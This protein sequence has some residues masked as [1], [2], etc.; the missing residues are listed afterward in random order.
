MEEIMNREKQDEFFHLFAKLTDGIMIVNH[1]GILLYLNPKAKMIF[2]VHSN[3]WVGR[4]IQ[5]LIPNIRMDI[6]TELDKKVLIGVTGDNDPLHI[7]IQTQAYTI[8]DHLYQ[9]VLVKDLQEDKNGLKQLR[10]ISKELADIK[11]ALDE[12]TIVAITDARGIITLVN[13]KFCELSKYKEEELNG[14]NHRILNSGYHSKEF[15]QDM[16]KTISRGEIWKGEIQNKAKDGSLYWVDTTIV[17]FIGDNGKPYQYVSIRTDITKRVLMEQELQ[18]SMKINFNETMKNLQNGIFRVKKDENGFFVYTMAEGKLL[19]EI[20]A[21]AGVLIGKSP[22]QVFA[23][24]IADMKQLKYEQ[25]FQGDRVSYELELGGKLVYVDV[26]PIKY[27]NHMTEV[28]GSVHDISELRLTQREL[29]VNQLQ[30]QSLLEHSQDYVMTFATNGQIVDMNSRAREYLSLVHP[31]QPI[32]NMNDLSYLEVFKSKQHHYFEKALQGKIQN[33]EL[34]LTPDRYFNITLLPIILDKQIKGVYSIG[35]DITK[36]KKIQEMNAYL[37]HHDE[38]TKLPNRRWIEQKLRDSI[39]EAVKNHHELAV[40][41]IDLDRFK[42]INDTLGHFIG[43]RLLQ[44]LAGRLEQSIEKNKQFVARLGGDEFMVVCPVIAHHEEVKNIAKNILQTLSTPFYIEDYELLVTASIGISTYPQDGTDIVDLMKKADIALYRAKEH[45]R[46]MYQVYVNTMDERNY[47][48][49]IL[50]RDLRKAIIND[51]FIAYLQP[52]VDAITGKT[53]G[54]EAL[55]RWIHPVL[56]LV[57]PGEFIPI[58]EETGL[59]I[60]IGKWMK[61]RVCEQLVAWIKKGVEPIPI[62]VNISSQRFLQKDFSKEVRELLEEY[63]LEGKWLEFEI[64]ENSLMRNE[65]YILQTL[66]DLKDM[67]IKIYIDDFGTGYSSFN[68]LKTFKLDGIKIDRSF[69]Q[70]ISSQSENAGITTAMI[71]MGQHLKMDVIAEGVETKEE[72]SFL[73]EQNCHHIQGFYFGKPC[74]IEEFEEKFMK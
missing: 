61:R 12:S 10:S 21:N 16:W 60:P 57:S 29:Q 56:G 4:S 72:L 65:E 33:F 34:E 41:F 17:P 66:Y 67:G 74:S 28:V 62:S 3:Q 51:E 63:Q 32:Q 25:A 18:E 42:N 50:E 6:E 30:Y 24:E 15:F 8:Q 59:I 49:F 13:Q 44:I 39:Q 46:N 22:H 27:G 58:A 23:K 7:H 71:K 19:D 52:R 36:Q 40:L 35:K 53:V 54:A 48:S 68:Y 11:L 38:L 5:T 69:I 70:H 14:Q 9:V 31:H 26:S 37:A 55:I 43:D 73:L 20:G 2:N 47:Q 1:L 64:T 45:G